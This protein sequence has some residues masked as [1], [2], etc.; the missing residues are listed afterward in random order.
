MRHGVCVTTSASAGYASGTQGT[1]RGGGGVSTP[2]QPVRKVPT[3]TQLLSGYTATVDAL[4][5][6][7]D[8]SEPGDTILLRSY[9][10]ERGESSSCVLGALQ[11]AADRG[12]RVKLGMDRS[13][14][15][16]IT[17]FLERSTTMEGELKALSETRPET[18]SFEPGDK[19]DHS[20]L[21]VLHKADDPSA[22][23]LILG[24]VNLGG[25]WPRGG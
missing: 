9:V 12:V 19:P 2:K 22:S 13:P 17:R 23:Q 5:Q 1:C 8:A 11:R 7:V 15:S 21:F 3:T 4:V 20:K 18:V 16:K 25:A 6:A 14:L 10:I 24:G